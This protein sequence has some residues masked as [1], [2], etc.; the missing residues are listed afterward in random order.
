MFGFVF[1]IFR[2]SIVG[3]SLDTSTSGNNTLENA[4]DR[5]KYQWDRLVLESL[6]AVEPSGR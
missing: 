3:E 6:I 2:E 4:W 1:W 5:Y